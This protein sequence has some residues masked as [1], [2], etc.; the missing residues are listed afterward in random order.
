M[1][2]AKN[3]LQ[4]LKKNAILGLKSKTLQKNNTKSIDKKF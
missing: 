2:F 1:Y 4:K 3:N